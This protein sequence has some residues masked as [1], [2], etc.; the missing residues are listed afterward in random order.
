MS[1]DFGAVA[2]AIIGAAAG[3]GV[4]GGTFFATGGNLPVAITAGVL[5]GLVVD[6][7]VDAL[8]ENKVPAPAKPQEKNHRRNSQ[9]NK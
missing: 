3:L 2:A 9:P 7:T 4:G 1:Q 6:K 8:L 5:A